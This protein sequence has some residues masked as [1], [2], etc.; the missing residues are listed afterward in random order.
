MVTVCRTLCTAVAVNGSA[1]DYYVYRNSIQFQFNIARGLLFHMIVLCIHV[2][3]VY[4]HVC[5]HV[6]YHM[7]EIFLRVNFFTDWVEMD[8]REVEVSFRSF[9]YI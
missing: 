4:L 8:F 7:A 5:V 1:C 6:L 2:Y 9:R 3:T